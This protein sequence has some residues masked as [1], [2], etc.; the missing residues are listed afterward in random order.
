MVIEGIFDLEQPLRI[1]RLLEDYFIKEKPMRKINPFP[2]SCCIL[3][4]AM[5]ACSTATP[6][7]VTPEPIDLNAAIA[8]TAA[9]AMTQTAL[10]LPPPS[11][12]FTAE[13]TLTA[14]ETATQTVTPTSIFTA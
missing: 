4:L 12:T 7:V 13:A 8:Q 3:F 2:L 11:Q 9:A 6:V 14:S 1:E 5:L 10:V